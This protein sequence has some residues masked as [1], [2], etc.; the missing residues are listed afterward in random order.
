MSSPIN[1][2]AAHE[3]YVNPQYQ[4]RVR[5][6]IATTWADESTRVSLHGMIDSGSAFWVR[7]AVLCV[8]PTC[9]SLA[10]PKRSRRSYVAQIDTIARIRDEA[11]DVTLETVFRDAASRPTPPL[12][13]VILYNLPNRDCHACV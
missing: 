11:N 6:S 1:L 2:F 13:V 8:A 9:A 4:A 7:L 10:N 12:V 3:Y 5:A